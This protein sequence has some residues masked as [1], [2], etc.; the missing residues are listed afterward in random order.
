MAALNTLIPLNSPTPSNFHP[1]LMGWMPA[2]RA[3]WVS[4][5]SNNIV[6]FLHTGSLDWNCDELTPARVE[7]TPHRQLVPDFKQL[8]HS[9]R[10][11]PQWKLINIGIHPCLQD[12]EP[13]DQV[14]SR[15]LCNIHSYHNYLY[16][17]RLYKTT[18][19]PT[20]KVFGETGTT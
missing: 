11:N 16:D 4:K 20:Y 8:F 7:K 18:Y 1:R 14:F 13:L 9:S 3:K 12:L 10:L 19:L 6:R 17:S 15:G 2:L 5:I